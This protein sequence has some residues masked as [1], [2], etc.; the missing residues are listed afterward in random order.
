MIVGV[1]NFISIWTIILIH[2]FIVHQIAKRFLNNFRD[3]IKE[4]LCKN[5]INLKYTLGIALKKCYVKIRKL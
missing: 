2:S 4:V 3:S 5:S 1:A